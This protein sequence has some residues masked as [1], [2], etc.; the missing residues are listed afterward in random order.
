[1]QT[2][3]PVLKKFQTFLSGISL[4]VL[5]VE[6]HKAVLN[7]RKP[8]CAKC[9]VSSKN[10]IIRLKKFLK[11]YLIDPKNSKGGPFGLPV[12]FGTL[13]IFNVVRDTTH[14]LLLLRPCN[15]DKISAL[16]TRPSG[17]EKLLTSPKLKNL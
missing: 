3:N 11:K 5:Q 12:T 17:S 15:Q 16:T 14:L 13:K 6:L 2:E 10:Q 4:R 7:L 9:F 8:H 1:M